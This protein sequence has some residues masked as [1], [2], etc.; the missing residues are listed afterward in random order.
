MR[1]RPRAFPVYFDADE[2]SA[3]QW[4]GFF[5]AGLEVVKHWLNQA[6]SVVD[7]TPNNFNAD[8]WFGGVP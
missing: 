3:I 5:K 2:V 6:A 7:L 8:L 1:Q 4:L